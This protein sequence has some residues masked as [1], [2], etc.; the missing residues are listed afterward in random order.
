[1]KQSE[2]AHDQIGTSHTSSKGSQ[3]LLFI[4]SPAQQVLDYFLYCQ[5][6]E[7]GA[8]SRP[9]EDEYQNPAGSSSLPK[10]HLELWGSGRQSL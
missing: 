7:V 5:N 1:M 6:E 4:V 2:G 3:S 9:R 10:D 8:Q